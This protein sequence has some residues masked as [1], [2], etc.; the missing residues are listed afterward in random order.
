MDGWLMMVPCQCLCL[1][2]QAL[3][4]LGGWWQHLIQQQHLNTLQGS[5]RKLMI[6]NLPP[7]APMLLACF[8]C[9]CCCWN[10][11]AMATRGK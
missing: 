8:C 6:Q 4:R 11:T 10:H 5:A 9:C 7:Q 1:A 2:P 3:I